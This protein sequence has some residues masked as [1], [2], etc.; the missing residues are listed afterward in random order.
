MQTLTAS[1]RESF[2]QSTAHWQLQPDRDAICR[3]FKFRD[4][5]AAWA[6]M[7][8]VAS[9]AERMDH[10]PEWSNTYNTVNIVLTTH[11]AGGLTRRDTVMAHAIDAVEA[12]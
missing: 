4:F 3:T 12:A 5:A 9:I 1:E 10:H 2:L 6:F 11:D 8:R 7:G